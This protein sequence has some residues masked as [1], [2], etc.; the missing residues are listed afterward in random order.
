[1]RDTLHKLVPFSHNNMELYWYS[2]RKKLRPSDPVTNTHLVSHLLSPRCR[3]CRADILTDTD[4]QPVA[5]DKITHH[6]RSPRTPESFCVQTAAAE[7]A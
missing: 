3:R 4:R 6:R 5:K 7:T 1:M 2:R